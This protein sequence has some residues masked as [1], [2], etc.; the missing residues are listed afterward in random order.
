MPPMRNQLPGTTTKIAF[1]FIV[2][3]GAAL[4]AYGYL[5]PASGSMLL[6]LILGGV[7]GV[8]VFLKLFWGRLLSGLGLRK[9]ADDQEEP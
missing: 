7:A 3:A 4:P 1:A 5:D 6:Q 2:L 8:A 9:D